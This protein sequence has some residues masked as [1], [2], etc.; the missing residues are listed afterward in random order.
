MRIGG[1]MGL[2]LDADSDE[3]NDAGWEQRAAFIVDRT[4]LINAYDSTTGSFDWQR[5]VKY[6]VDLPSDGN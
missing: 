3:Q 1:R 6:R 4:E 5:L 2:D